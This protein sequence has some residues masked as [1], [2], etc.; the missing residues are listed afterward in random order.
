M[1]RL[2]RT[3][4]GPALKRTPLGPATAVATEG[5]L[6][7]PSPEGTPAGDG[8]GS[9]GAPRVPGAAAAALLNP[10]DSAGRLVTSTCTGVCRAGEETQSAAASAPWESGTPIWSDRRV[11]RRSAPLHLGCRGLGHGGCRVQA[12]SP[13]A[14]DDTADGKAHRVGGGKEGR[15]SLPGPANHARV[16]PRTPIKAG[17]TYPSVP[18]DTRLPNG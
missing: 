15:G 11:G 9:A 17:L 16:P 10:D 18:S 13:T 14:L 2:S 1:G 6:A 3:G 7:S 8:P 5:L 12:F 4:A